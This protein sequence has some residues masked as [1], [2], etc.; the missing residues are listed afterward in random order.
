MFLWVFS[1]IPLLIFFCCKCLKKSWCVSD[2]KV[3]VIYHFDLCSFKMLFSYF[4][5][6]VSGR[7][8]T[9][10]LLPAP[11]PFFLSCPLEKSVGPSPASTDSLKGFWIGRVKGQTGGGRSLFKHAHMVAKHPGCFFLSLLLFL[12]CCSSFLRKLVL[13]VQKILDC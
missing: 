10:M 4:P 7:E 11:L 2:V 1:S 3:T 12:C 8:V 6:L 13:G 5:F 9:C